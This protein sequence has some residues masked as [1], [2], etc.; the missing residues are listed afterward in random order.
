[1]EPK[2]PMTHKEWIVVEGKHNKQQLEN[3][4]FSNFFRKFEKNSVLVKCCLERWKLRKFKMFGLLF[5][6]FCLNSDPF[7]VYHGFLW[8]HLSV[9][10]PIMAMRSE[11]STFGILIKRQQFC[12]QNVVSVH[13]MTKN[14]VFV[15]FQALVS[16]FWGEI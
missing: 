3:F 1:M 8:F 9:F 7:F 5:F 11:N 15:N 16:R 12:W 2:K 14:R 4:E 13:K 10:K 6:V